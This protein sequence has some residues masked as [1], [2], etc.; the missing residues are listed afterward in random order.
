[1]L[2]HIIFTFI[3]EFNVPIR[4]DNVYIKLNFTISHSNG[5]VIRYIKNIQMIKGT[6]LLALLCLCTA[7]V[8]YDKFMV[9]DP[10]AF[11]LDGS[12]PAYFLKKENNAKWVIT[13]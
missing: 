9:S 3:L 5:F 12:K 8:T 2:C 7:L 13:F 4:I 6:F 1:M 10:D 11:C